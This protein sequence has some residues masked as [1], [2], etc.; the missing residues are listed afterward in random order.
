MVL[1]NCSGADPRRAIDVY[2]GKVL[3]ALARAPAR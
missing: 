3:P 2:G 1:M